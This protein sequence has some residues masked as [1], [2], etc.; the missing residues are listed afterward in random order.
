MIKVSKV[1]YDSSSKRLAPRAIEVL[2]LL[3]DGKTNAQIAEE[4]FISTS[5]VKDYMGD[6]LKAFEVP[7]RTALGAIISK[8]F[9]KDYE[10]D[11]K[12][13]YLLNLN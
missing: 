5:T 1:L 13:R 6:L 10:N 4:L 7:D 8:Y 2:L 11:E 9:P 12:Y 3:R